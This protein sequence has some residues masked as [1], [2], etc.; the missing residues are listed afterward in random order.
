MANIKHL[1]SR[2]QQKHDVEAN[3]LIAGEPGENKTPFIPMVGEIIVYDADEN[4]NYPRFKIGDGVTT[5][6]LLPFYGDYLVSLIEDLNR[7]FEEYVELDTITALTPAIATVNNEVLV[8]EDENGEQWT[9]VAA[10]GV[11]I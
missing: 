9:L 11:A 10:D 3:W 6:T 8:F 1:K 7:R 5:V 4:H 2:F